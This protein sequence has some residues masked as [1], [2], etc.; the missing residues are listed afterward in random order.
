MPFLALSDQTRKSIPLVMA[1][2]LT[3][4]RTKRDFNNRHKSKFPINSRH[5]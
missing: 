1:F 3:K 5:K 2:N 4:E